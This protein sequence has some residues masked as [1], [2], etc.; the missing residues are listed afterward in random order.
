MKQEDIF[1]VLLNKGY[2]ELQAKRLSKELLALSPDLANC[3]DTWAEEGAEKDYT[4]HG[5]YVKEIITKY[6][7]K[8]P[9]ALLSIDWVLKDPEHAIPVIKRGV[10]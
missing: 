5:M 9:A 10:R 7:L 3:F 4:A 1:K 2:N 6:S 8:Y